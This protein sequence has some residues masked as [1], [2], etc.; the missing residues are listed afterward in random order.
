MSKIMSISWSDWRNFNLPFNVIVL[1]SF[2]G[3]TL[4][5]YVLFLL[6]RSPLSSLLSGCV[7]LD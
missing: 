6:F 3:V 1:Y 4:L 2:C 7:W 5:D